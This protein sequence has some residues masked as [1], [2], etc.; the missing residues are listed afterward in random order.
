MKGAMRQTRGKLHTCGT[1]L[2]PPMPTGI[3]SSTI[4]DAIHPNCCS[5]RCIIQLWVHLSLVR[6][7]GRC[8]DSSPTAHV[9]PVAAHTLTHMQKHNTQ[10]LF[11][12]RRSSRE[13]QYRGTGWGKGRRGAR[14]FPLAAGAGVVQ[15]RP[16]LSPLVPLA[17]SSPRCAKTR[18]GS[19]APAVSSSPKEE[20]HKEIAAPRTPIL[21]RR[22]DAGVP[23]AARRRCR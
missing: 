22:Q 21:A 2:S 19:R 9:I 11:T 7:R 8:S 10:T 14:S 4:A 1:F 5:V 18:K 23:F 17:P 3:I 16:R 12:G 13:R 6:R 15:L 20:E